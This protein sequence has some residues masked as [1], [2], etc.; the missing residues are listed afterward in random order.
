MCEYMCVC[1]RETAVKREA[2]QASQFPFPPHSS[3]ELCHKITPC[4]LPHY[5][6]WHCLQG[7]DEGVG[8]YRSYS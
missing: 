3:W 1:S 7:K 5:V 2:G 8:K 4:R 6:S